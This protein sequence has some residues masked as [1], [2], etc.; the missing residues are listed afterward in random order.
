MKEVSSEVSEHIDLDP[1]EKFEDLEDAPRE[2]L[3]LSPR[4]S[5]PPFISPLNSL[6]QSLGIDLVQQE[7]YDYIESLE[8]KE[9]ATKG[10]I[11]SPKEEINQFNEPQEPP[12]SNVLKREIFELETLNR[13][14]KTKNQ[15]LKKQNGIQISKSDNLILHLSLWYKMNKKLKKENKAMKREIINLKYKILMKKPWQ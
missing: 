6:V 12:A 1:K 15:T 13:Y 14:L 9:A 4:V 10:S 3:R 2:S 8:R 5:P 11:Q 7:I